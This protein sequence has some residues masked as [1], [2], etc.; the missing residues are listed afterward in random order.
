MDLDL[1][2]LVSVWEAEGRKSEDPSPT[3][4]AEKEKATLHVANSYLRF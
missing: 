1:L 3:V 4:Q 2:G